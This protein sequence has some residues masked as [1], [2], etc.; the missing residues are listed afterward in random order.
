MELRLHQPQA[1]VY[2]AGV[3]K[4]KGGKG[5]RFRSLCAGRRGGKTTLMIAEL[6]NRALAPKHF[7]IVSPRPKLWYIG[8]TY[9]QAKE[10][11]WEDLFHWVGHLVVKKNES[12][13]SV[14]FRSGAILALRG[15]DNANRL[16]GPGLDFVCMDEFADIKDGKNAWEKV[17]RPML[18][19]RRG[20]ALIAGTPRGRNHFYEL[21]Q[22]A[23]QLPGWAAFA[24]TTEQGGIVERNEI[25][26]ARKQLDDK[27]FRQEFMAT[28]ESFQGSAYYAYETEVHRRECQFNPQLPVCFCLDFNVDPMSAAIAQIYDLGLGTRHGRRVEV[29]DEI[30]IPN[31]HVLEA[32][33]AFDRKMGKYAERYGMTVYVYADASG[34]NR[35]ATSGTTAIAVV[36]EWFKRHPNY[37]V[38]YRIPDANPA[39]ADRIRSV[40]QMLRNVVGQVRLHIDPRCKELLKDFDTIV[41]SNELGIDI[42]KSDPK[43]T[44]MSDALGYMI[45]YEFATQQGQGWRSQVLV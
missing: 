45:D 40:N 5:Y 12:D 6:V 7:G 22:E 34:N 11:I 17:V 23:K 33:E 20:G 35:S 18:A 41:W 4:T 38:S 24:Y 29:V 2:W 14:R 16:R 37:R 43:R 27:S 8:P 36:K 10:V 42:D 25:E 39:V 44:H 30:S 15:A 9:R 32:C 21:H 13:L 26:S 3:P 31:S 28:F 1:N 19:D